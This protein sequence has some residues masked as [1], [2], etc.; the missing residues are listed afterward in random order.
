MIYQV[1]KKYTKY[2]NYR[3]SPGLSIKN[4]QVKIECLIALAVISE[5]T[6]I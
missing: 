6:V 1:Q 3:L 4:R 2:H 5:R